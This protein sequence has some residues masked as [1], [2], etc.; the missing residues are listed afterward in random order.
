MACDMFLKID[1]ITG[2]TSADGMSGY[3]SILSFSFG[4]SNAT[5]VGPGSGG[6]TG[7]RSSLSD[8]S[9]M[10]STESASTDLFL[11]CASGKSYASAEVVIRKA[12]GDGGQQTFLKYSFTNIMITSVQWSGGGDE[13]TEAL[14][15]AFQAVTI[16]YSKQGD[17][18]S[19]T[20]S[21]NCTWDQT[22][23]KS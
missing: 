17:D 4:V 23:V 21:G 9:V 2:E 19:M 18:G 10:K 3:M 13:P 22:K 7:G 20:P 12:T 11:H 8:F 1:G 5:T 6:L 15:F 14:S 16:E